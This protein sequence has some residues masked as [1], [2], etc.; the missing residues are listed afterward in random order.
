MQRLLQC[1]M[2]L[3]NRLLRIDCAFQRTKDLQRRKE[4]VTKPTLYLQYYAKAYN[5]LA[6]PISA[7]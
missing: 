3:C 6:V 5:E 4:L 2:L 1:S 7:S